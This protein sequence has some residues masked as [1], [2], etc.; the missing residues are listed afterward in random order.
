[1]QDAQ[2]SPTETRT[3]NDGATWKKPGSVMSFRSGGIIGRSRGTS[4]VS[5][6]VVEDDDYN[7]VVPGARPRTRGSDRR[8]TSRAERLQQLERAASSH[9][10]TP[11][12]SVHSVPLAHPTP[13]L[14]AIQ[15]AYVANVEHLERTAESFDLAS[16]ERASVLDNAHQRPASSAH[17]HAA[18]PMSSWSRASRASANYRGG[19]NIMS[20]P[21]S[22]VRP[23]TRSG[24]VA[25]KLARVIEPENEG[26]HDD[27]GHR[28]IAHSTIPHGAEETQFYSAHPQQSA[29]VSPVAYGAPEHFPAL[30]EEEPADRPTSAGLDDVYD[31]GPHMFFEN[32]NGVHYLPWRK[33][34]IPTRRVSITQ[35]PLASQPVRHDKPAPGM[36]Y[37]PAPVPMVLNLPQKTVH[38]PQEEDIAKRQSE[39]VHSL[40]ADAS[41]S[42]AWLPGPEPFDDAKAKRASAAPPHARASAF[43]AQQPQKLEAKPKDQSAVNFLEG[44]LDASADAPVGKFVNHPMAGEAGA[45]EVYG[46]LKKKKNKDKGGHEK[47]RSVA[48]SAGLRDSVPSLNHIRMPSEGQLGQHE[49]DAANQVDEETPFRRSYEQ[50]ED[51]GNQ[52][53][54]YDRGHEYE[55]N[56]REE[57]YDDDED[58]QGKRADAESS[59]GEYEEEDDTNEAFVGRP[60]TLIA[61]LQ[62]R[63]REQKQRRRHVPQSHGPLRSTLLELD[64]VAQ[65][66]R[67]ERIRK[68]ITLAWQDP[69]PEERR[70]SDDED[71][72]LGLLLQKTRLQAD[73][74]RPTGLMEQL[75][76]D[77]HETLAQRRARLK[78]TSAVFPHPGMVQE[79]NDSDDEPLA[80]RRERLK[81]QAASNAEPLQSDFASEVLSK[82]KPEPAE[83]SD[84]D[85]GETLAERRR[86]LKA[87]AAASGRQAPSR[88]STANR[89]IP[90]HPYMEEPFATQSQPRFSGELPMGRDLV[91][92]DY[93]HQRRTSELPATYYQQHGS[94]QQPMSYPQQRTFDQPMVYPQQR[95]MSMMDQNRVSMPMLG[96]NPHPS[97]VSDMPYNLPYRNSRATPYGNGMNAVDPS[98]HPPNGHQA[99]FAQIQRLAGQPQSFAGQMERSHARINSWRQNVQP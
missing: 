13:D 84:S 24:S 91:Q 44:V 17:E 54:H 32:F 65:R 50:Y 85:P 5:Y 73:E 98:Y 14:Q 46:K 39:F 45:E 34:S 96:P 68:N 88:L 52:R 97:Q 31:E 58:N 59:E 78:G 79:E 66:Q 57:Y 3:T 7:V 83:E 70:E 94:F 48:L 16:H 4:A 82:F 67:Q 95:H 18:R 53:F 74:D 26:D 62:I 93:T 72:P 71:V 55:S 10:H 51:E 22:Q 19:N 25:S 38:E 76:A 42:A 29:P 75:D 37:Y 63:K 23:R 60:A 27:Y 47:H 12:H 90:H 77:A 11:V 99:S 9:P 69:G 8:S 40:P 20:S 15:G 43:F 89:S 28:P 6:E 86:R 30:P 61:E 92:Q 87:E 33:N 41:K 49:T 81:A 80:V 36:V 56:S 64:T 35:P 2:I 21:D 1:M